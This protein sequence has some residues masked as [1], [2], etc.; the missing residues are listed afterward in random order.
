MEETK[1]A[2]A[3]AWATDLSAREWAQIEHA[4]T[5]AFMFDDAGVPG[6][7]QFLLIAKLAKK[8]NEREPHESGGE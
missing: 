5:Y 6:H 8:L 1:R 2:N 7:G 3:P 4:R